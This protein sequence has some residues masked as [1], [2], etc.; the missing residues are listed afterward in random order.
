MERFKLER[1][2]NFI[3]KAITDHTWESGAVFNPGV[4][5][6]NDEIHLLYRAVE[7]NNYSSIGYAR[8]DLKGNVLQRWDKP[9]IAREWPIEKHGCEDPRIVFFENRYLIFYTGFDGKNPQK[10]E[11]ARII[12]AE[13]ADFISYKKIAMV[14]P[15]RQDKDAMIFPEKIKDKVAFIHRIEPNIHLAYFDD[16]EHLSKPE[17]T[18]WP[19]H[20]KN[21]QNHTLLYPVFNWETKKIGVGPPPLRTDAGWL[22]IYHGVDNAMTY[23]AGAAL[24]DINDPFKIIARLPYPILEPEKEYEK[25]GDVNM[26]VFPQG[27]IVSNNELQVYYGAADKV[28]G[29]AVCKVSDIIDAL[30]KHR[31]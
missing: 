18:Y 30:W 29:F 28:I 10:G 9:V 8:L 2:N 22:L 5:G 17:I 24:L 15:D 14:G 25:I 12:M 20:I 4:A 1:V 21:L 23:R 27:A 7:G 19:D 3:M 16:I 26:V 6:K 11:N 31:S 13:T